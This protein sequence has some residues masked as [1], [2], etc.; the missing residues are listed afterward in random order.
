MAAQT[1]LR[2]VFAILCLG[3]HEGR[4][5]VGHFGKAIERYD[6]TDS[7][8]L[9]GVVRLSDARL[10]SKNSFRIRDIRR[11]F[12]LKIDVRATF[13]AIFS[14]FKLFFATI[15]LNEV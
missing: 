14:N 10:T 1:S 13:G 11:S 12:Q 15:G 7:S 4:H 8:Q 2:P 3:I 5:D 9:A 6:F